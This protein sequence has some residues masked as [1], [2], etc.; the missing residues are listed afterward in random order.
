MLQQLS[1]RNIVLV[2]Q[3]D[4][5]L[6][7]G[8]IVLSGETGAGKS[9]LLDAFALVLGERA[10]PRL[11]RHGT[12]KGEV[13]AG[14]T[15]P[16]RLVTTL[17]EADI[18]VEDTLWIRRVIT[19]QGQ[20]RAYINDTPATL[21]L[22]KTIGEQLV[23]IHG[24]H[25]QR[26]LMDA[27]LHREWVDAYGNHAPMLAETKAAYHAMKEAQTALDTLNKKLAAAQ[28]EQDYLE[29]MARELHALAPEEGEDEALADARQTMMGHE[30]TAAILDDVMQEL[31]QP[32]LLA[33]GLRKAQS[34][35]LR[36]FADSEEGNRA[37]DAL[38]Q[39]QLCVQEA[40]DAILTLGRNAHYNPKELEQIEERLFALR[41]IA[42]KYQVPPDALHTLLAEVDG[43]LAALETASAA[44]VTLEHALHE[45]TNTYA[46]H[47]TTL[48]NARTTTARRLE[49]ALSKELTPLKMASA[50]L[51]VCIEQR[52]QPQWAEH[53]M[54]DIHFLAATN[55]GQPPAPLDAIAS[56]GELSR[57]L[58]ALAVALGEVHATPVMIFD[59]I[60]TG[61]GGA[62][63]DAIGARLHALAEHVQVLVVTHQPQVAAKGAQHVF[64]SKA[65]DSGG[66]TTTQVRTLS[67]PER[68]EELARM[69]S[70]AE[71]TDEARN[72]ALRLRTAS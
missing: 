29:H 46:T 3:A 71:I 48:H 56:G 44:Q 61:T 2:E 1:I 26:S 12:D 36:S 65:E 41:G 24:Q 22:L 9:I 32:R 59:E 7:A 4:L 54:D 43:K 21:K 8:L 50:Q 31:T 57:F 60:D 23:E 18:P 19:A 52:P 45:A 72:A 55:A 13:R 16:E 15:M 34:I 63:A 38:E 20:S 58:L 25:R 47:A 6:H 51:L 5:L 28:K 37:I 64:V 62:V 66:H 10:D 33:E 67:D 27:S 17:E 70:G 30:K 14:F 11:I 49:Q 40:E 39:A 68:N 69:L 35:L 42:R 53:G